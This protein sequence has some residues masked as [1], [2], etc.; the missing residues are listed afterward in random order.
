MSLCRKEGIN[1][2]LPLVEGVPGGGKKRLAGDA[3]REAISDEVSF[4]AYSP[5][6]SGVLLLV[7]QPRRAPNE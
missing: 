3:A 1:Q 2:K 6:I 4:T 7:S 5:Q